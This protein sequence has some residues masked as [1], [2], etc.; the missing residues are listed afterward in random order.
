[1]V[2]PPG[3]RVCVTDLEGDV[4]GGHVSHVRPGGAVCLPLKESHARMSFV[5]RTWHSFKASRLLLFSTSRQKQA[6]DLPR[7]G[8]APPHVYTHTRA[9]FGLVVIA[10]QSLSGHRTGTFGRVTLA[11]YR[12]AHT[13]TP[14]GPQSKSLLCEGAHCRVCRADTKVFVLCTVLHQTLLFIVWKASDASSQLFGYAYILF[15]LVRTDVCKKA[16]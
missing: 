11:E 5:R 10:S 4:E 15:H 2:W 16:T 9:H 12:T 6:P 13:V 7:P 3:L 1:M 14:F 8:R